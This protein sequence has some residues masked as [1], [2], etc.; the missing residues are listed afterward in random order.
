MGFLSSLFSKSK[1]ENNTK[2]HNDGLDCPDTS[3]WITIEVDDLMRGLRLQI[4]PKMEYYISSEG[5]MITLKLHENASAT[6]N[7]E[8][9]YNDF[10]IAEQREWVMDPDNRE[11][12]V[13]VI[14]EGNLAY[15]TCT[16]I[17]ANT[18]NQFSHNCFAETHLRGMRFFMSVD[19]I[20]FDMDNKAYNLSQRECLTFLSI[21]KS[22]HLTNLK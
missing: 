13:W 20:S 16:D 19:G 1:T 2:K 5:G 14:D 8:G 21:F 9:G 4:P 7:R 12:L 10:D 22:M 15:F 11:D 18:A 6:I 17:S 3:N